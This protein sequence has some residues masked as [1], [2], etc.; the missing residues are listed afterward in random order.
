MNQCDFLIVGGG[1]VG[2]AIARSIQAHSPKASILILEKESS[3]GLHASGRNSGVLHTGIYYPSTTMKAR[4][5]RQGAQALMEYATDRK[6]PWRRDG[7]LILATSSEEEKAFEALLKN[8]RDNGISARLVSSD[9][10]R[11]I[12]PH[13]RPGHSALFCEDTSVIDSKAVLKSLAQELEASGVSILLNQRVEKI[14]LKSST[15]ESQNRKFGFGYLI[16]A[17]GAFADSIAHLCGFGEKYRF[18]PFKGIYYRMREDVAPRI[19]GSI[20][21]VPNPQLPFLGVHFTRVISGD[22]YI[23]PTAIPALGREN[24]GL[25]DG[26]SLQEMGQVLLQLSRAFLAN[27]QGFRQLVRRE[28]P[29]Y[30]KSRFYAQAKRLVDELHEDWIEPS[31]KVGIRPQLVN[32]KEARLEMDFLMEKGPNSLHVLNSISPAFTS[33]LA[34]GQYVCEQIFDSNKE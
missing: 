31:A 34:V 18:L 33:S 13:A 2:L 32:L 8:A 30:L 20:Y 22:V 12:E 19:R 23:G 9:E 26:A 14:D 17:A 5:C 3:L 24:Y 7:K 21:P 28:A 10:A 16:N 1:I 6:I 11:T 27:H 25:L 29:M 15:L 4:F